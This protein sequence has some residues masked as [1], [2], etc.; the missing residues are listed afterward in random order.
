MYFKYGNYTHETGEVTFSIEKNNEYSS[1]GILTAIVERWTIRGQI[2]ADSVSALTAKLVAL[3]NAYAVD[4]LSFGLYEDDGTATAHTINHSKMEYVRVVN[5]PSFPES[6]GAEY[7]TFRNYTIQIEA[8]YTTA[9]IAG[10]AVLS[11]SENISV[12]GGGPRVIWIETLNGPPQMQTTCE[13]T[14][15]TATQS[16]RAVGRAAYPAPPAPLWSLTQPPQI[17]YE[18][19]EQKTGEK[20]N[21]GVRWQYQFQSGSP[22]IGY[23]NTM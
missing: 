19:P 14:M 10:I 1:G 11:F 4:N 22:L 6:G 7:T 21:Y 9:A 12:T 5:P 2:H 3:K 18:S 20:T 23:P 13:Q 16:G 8:R 17:E 15:Y